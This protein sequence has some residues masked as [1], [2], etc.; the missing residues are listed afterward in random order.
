VRDLFKDVFDV[1]QDQDFGVHESADKTAIRLYEAGEGEGPDHKNLR[2]DME[3]G[4]ESKWNERVVDILLQVLKG[5]RDEEDWR[6]P[7]ASDR[8]LTG[9]ITSKMKRVKSYWK[10]A[11]P[12][13]TATGKMETPAEL[14]ERL[15]AKDD[16]Y[17]IMTRESQRRRSVSNDPLNI[18]MATDER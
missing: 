17:G 13:M 1:E 4:P 12:R 10:E 7:A 6:L 14:E 9:L 18:R 3:T 2:I 15:N 16:R 8:Y 11:Q 5:R